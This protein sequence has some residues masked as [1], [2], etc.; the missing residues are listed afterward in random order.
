MDNQLRTQLR[1]R[2]RR[3]LRLYFRYLSQNI[4]SLMSYRADF[5]LGF[6]GFLGNQLL[7]VAFI[8]FVF[9]AVPSLAGWSFNEILF[10]YG[11][12]Q[13]PRGLDHIFTDNLWILAWRLV[14]KGDFDRFLLRPLS[15]LFQVLADRF[16]P[17][18]AGELVAGIAI[19]SVAWS[20]LGLGTDPLRLA[21][22]APAIA[23]GFLIYT[24]V[25]L[26]LASAAF[27]VKNSQGYLFAA[28]KVADFAMYPVGIFPGALRFI[29]TFVLPFAFTS[30]YP[31]AA[32]L[33]RESIAL[34]IFGSLAAGIAASALAGLAWKAGL[35]AYESAGS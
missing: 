26:S 6:L 3:Y 32:L 14:A 21:L 17:D 24:A 16:Q 5:I 35:R 11:F 27:W 31:A 9:A 29:M 22:L 20:R 25:K 30:Y 33:G 19:L 18:G 8:G 34:G 13:I 12:A 2:R 10:I 15:P 7:G 1:P 4:K 28:Y 23:G